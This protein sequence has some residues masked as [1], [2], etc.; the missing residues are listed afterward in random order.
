MWVQPCEMP[1]RWLGLE[2]PGVSPL[3]PCEKFFPV[4]HDF[5]PILCFCLSMT[6]F[7]HNVLLTH[8]R[9]RKTEGKV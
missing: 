8:M 2:V 3:L 4:K 6:I 9:H 5:S 7:S 1:N